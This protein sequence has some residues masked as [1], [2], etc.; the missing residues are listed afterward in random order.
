MR[1]D[2]RGYRIEVYLIEER[3]KPAKKGAGPWIPRAKVS[4]QENG[5]WKTE[6]LTQDNSYRFRDRAEKAGFEIAKQWINAREA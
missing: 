6:L 3:I 4:W 2:Y 5:K 1:E